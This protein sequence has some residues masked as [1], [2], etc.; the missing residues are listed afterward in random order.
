MTN[1]TTTTDAGQDDVQGFFLAFVI[2][3]AIGYAVTKAIIG[4]EG[5]G[6]A[7][8]LGQQALTTA[9]SLSDWHAVPSGLEHPTMATTAQHPST[10]PVR[11]VRTRE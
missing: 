11:K 1:F 5:D 8:W 4:S 6:G 7:A 9:H 3:A 10:H 2:G